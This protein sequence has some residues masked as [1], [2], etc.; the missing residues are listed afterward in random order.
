MTKLIPY[1]KSNKWGFSNSAKEIVIK[2]NYDDIIIPFSESNFNLALVSKNKK[3][4]WINTKGIEITPFADMTHQFTDKGISVIILNKEI[5]TVSVFPN[6]LFVGQNGQVLFENDL[7]TSNGYQ[8][9]LCI[10]MN[11]ERKYG[12]GKT[13]EDPW[14]D[15]WTRDRS[16]IYSLG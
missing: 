2:C 1:R 6:C 14:E 3:T 13:A 4:C 9:G 11:K 12:A 8:N 5:D 15:P 10:A 7:L 16:D